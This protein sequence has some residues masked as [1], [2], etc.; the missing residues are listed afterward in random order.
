M[1]ADK[2][3]DAVIIATPDHHHA[4]MTI[5]AV[6]AGKHVYCEKSLIRREEEINAVYEAVKSS[7]QVFQLGHQIPQNAVF[8]KAKE[9][10][11]RGTL[12]KV[13]HVETTTNRNSR[14]GAWI[15]H[16]DADGNPKPGDERSI[17]WE[18]WLGPLPYSPFSIERYYGWAR[19]FDY[20]T[21][22]YGQLFSHEF[23]AVNQALELGIPKTALASGGQ[24]FY[25]DYGEIPDVLHTVFE[26]PDSGLTLT[27]SAN[28][29]SSKSRP[30][31][32][33]G[34]DA[35][36]T[37]GSD[38]TLTP[39][40]NS[41]QF[42][43]LIVRGVVDPSNPMLTIQNGDGGPDAVTSA[44]SSYYAQRGLIGTIIGGLN[45][46]VT[47]LHVKEWLECIRNGGE[48]TANIHKAYEESVA[49]A[50]A[51]ISYREGCMTQWDPVKR[52]ILRG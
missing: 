21:G 39:D 32:I 6:K 35:S 28:L 25:K 11:Q 13:S 7:N 22:L 37:L 45:W 4:Q 34:K 24:Y 23:D 49:I 14:H 47:H 43:D 46:D 30:R 8:Q 20:D 27:Y 41:S 52:K 5:D 48:T 50:M 26:Y 19:Y 18:Q 17:D 31:T 10:I 2:N 1:L 51:D 15:R 44:T 9:I 42:Q 40:R 16:L 3:I 38:L 29:A 36:M 33:Y 12:G